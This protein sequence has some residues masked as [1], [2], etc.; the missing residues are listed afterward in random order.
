MD[1]QETV[2][3]LAL[4]DRSGKMV[5]HSSVLVNRKLTVTVCLILLFK[6]CIEAEISEN[7]ILSNL[8]SVHAS[9]WRLGCGLQTRMQG[10]FMPYM[11]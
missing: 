4:L 10:I 5:G 8:G 1:E 11:L 2:L 6:C 9:K 7:V 3:S